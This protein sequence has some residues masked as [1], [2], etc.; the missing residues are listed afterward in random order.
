MYSMERGKWRESSG[1]GHPPISV[2]EKP[3]GTRRACRLA[4]GIRNHGGIDM[5]LSFLFKGKKVITETRT[6]YSGGSTLRFAKVISLL[7]AEL[8][9]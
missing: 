1:D 2:L 9:R 5:R 6:A 8:L 7:A 3:L 4:R